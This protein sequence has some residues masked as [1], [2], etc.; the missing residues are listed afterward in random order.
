MEYLESMKKVE[1][2]VQMGDNSLPKTVDA[3]SP[4]TSHSITLLVKLPI[5][6]PVPLPC[7]VSISSQ[8]SKF[9]LKFRKKLK[10]RGRPKRAVRQLCSFNKSAADRVSRKCADTDSAST[11][12][13]KRHKYQLCPVCGSCLLYTS[14]SPR[15]RTR[16][17]MPSSA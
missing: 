17:R 12:S 8:A 6:V 9:Q 14:P 10:A 5:A 11:V 16:S 7:S 2:A 13:Q 4:P 3:S 15:D 1:E